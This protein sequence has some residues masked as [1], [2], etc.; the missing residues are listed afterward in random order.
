LVHVSNTAEWTVPGEGQKSGWGTFKRGLTPYDRFM[1]EQEIPIHRGIGVHRVQE[2]PLKHWKRIGGDATFVQLYGTEGKWG[3][4]IVEVPAGGALNVQRH[5]W[6]DIVYVVSGR[7]STE[8]WQNDE[9]RKKVFEWSAGS[10]FAIP[11]NATHRIVNATQDPALLLVAT[12]APNIINLV[13]NTDFVFGSDFAFTDQFDEQD[14]FYQP[15]D[16]LVPDPVRGLAMQR[17]N[18]IPDLATCELPLDNRRSPGYRRIEP[19]M[20]SET[21]YMFCGQHEPGRYSKAHAHESGAVLICLSGKGYTYT[22][23]KA[24]GATPWQDGHGDLVKMQE[25]EPVGM[26]TAAP[27]NG[28]WFHQHFGAS[29]EPL[30][31]LALF[32]N[33]DTHRRGGTPGAEMKD[34]SSI[35]LKDG[36]IAI[37]Y[38]DEDPYVRQE[39]DRRLKAA[40]AVNR[41]SA[42][43]YD[44]TFEFAAAPPE[45]H[46]HS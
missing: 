18:L 37:D 23:P 29:N 3:M 44:A 17:T 40:G 25:Y 36:G 27:M 31:L 12:T 4:Q 26:V 30:R 10:L 19:H 33:S 42:E 41:M 11:L 32:G 38:R 20:A 43:V 14:D 28:D 35:S 15:K 45:E 8:V 46:S 34:Y 1:E 39:Y 13:Q 5:L 9:R 21:H 2:L 16:D 22:W 24:L 6:E 7:G